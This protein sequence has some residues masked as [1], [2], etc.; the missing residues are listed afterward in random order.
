MAWK[1]KK[2]AWK[3]KLCCRH[4]PWPAACPITASELGLLAGVLPVPYR[5]DS[6]ACVPAGVRP[7]CAK[8]A[9]ALS[10]TRELWLSRDA[11]LLHLVGRTE[12]ERFSNAGPFRCALDSASQGRPKIFILPFAGS[13]AYLK[14]H[15]IPDM[16]IAVS[17][18]LEPILTC[19]QRPTC[20]T[21]S[22]I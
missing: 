11:P 16:R 22:S 21:E 20:P 18:H 7:E 17:L 9:L 19:R 15:N 6:W 12:E 13:A 3:I 5:L 14:K 1:N 8:A 4:G 10:P 2:K